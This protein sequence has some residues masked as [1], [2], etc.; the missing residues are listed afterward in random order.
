MKVEWRYVIRFFVR[1]GVKGM[2]I[3]NGLSKHDGRDAF[4]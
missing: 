1:E 3:I 2:E 4:Q